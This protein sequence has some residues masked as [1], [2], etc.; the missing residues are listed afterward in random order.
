MSASPSQFDPNVRFDDLVELTRPRSVMIV[1]ASSKPG[2]LGHTTVVNVLE[3]SDF[4]GEVYLVNPKGGEL[5]GK[6]LHASVAAVPAQGIDV[7]LLLVPAESAVDTLRACADKGVR[8]VIVFTGGFAEL[9]EAGRTVEAEMLALAQRSGMRL[10]GPNC[11][12]MTMLAPRLGLTFSTE[13][14]NDGRTGKLS[15]IGLVTQGGGLGRSLMQGN[16]RGVCFSRWFSTGNEL[17][18]DSAD[19]INWLAHDPGTD[20]ICTVMEG[21]RSGPR[22][23]AAAAAA[24]RAGKPLI[25]LKIGRSDFGKKAAQSHTASLAGEDAVNDAVFSQYGVIRVEDLDELLDVASLISRVGA[26]SLRNICVYSSSGGAGVL[27]ADK[28][29][30]AGLSMAVL[31]DETV[32]E[33][34]RHAPAYAALTNPVDLTTKALT[35]PD[36]A[37]RCLAPLFADPGVDAVLYPITSNYSASTEGL[38]RNMLAVAQ[39]GAKA[40]VPVWMSSRRGPA[41]DLLIQEGFA[42]VYSLRNAML[43][44]KRVSGY[45]AQA[46]EVAQAAGGVEDT[47]PAGLPAAAPAV[48]LPCNE[49]QAKALLAQYGVRA[50]RESQAATAEDAAEAARAIGFPVALKLVADGVLHKSEIGGVQLGL[51]DEAEVRAAFERILANAARHQVPA[52]AIRGALVSEM[53]VNGVEMLVGLHRDEVFGPVLSVGAGGVWVEVDADVARC[54]LPASRQQIEHALDQTRIARRLAS[55]RGLPARDR[56]ALVDAVQRIAALFTALGDGVQSLEVNPLVVLDAG[57]GVVA[58]DAV[59]E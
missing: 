48:Q 5:F 17:D 51:R 41:H 10:Y 23:I 28:V 13:F 25:A 15:S 50:P 14:R 22:F 9:G 1:G 55:H 53:V 52:A 59:I 29:G 35:D 36:L 16:E 20:L 54:H 33:M 7:A 39:G 19:F 11:A 31:A 30:E 27:S 38:V 21:I 37:R 34:A 57:R 49:A 46:V 2:T 8:Y 24:R 3:H 40:F 6:P 44:L 43:A 45:A 18:L 47:A 4:D 58:L 26:R 32:A 42:P 56:A 12:G